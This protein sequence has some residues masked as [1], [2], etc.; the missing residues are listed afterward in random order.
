MQA[1]LHFL[2]RVCQAVDAKVVL[3]YDGVLLGLSSLDNDEDRLRQ[4]MVE[5][6][7]AFLWSCYRNVLDTLSNNQTLHDLYHKVC[8]RAF[9]IC[10]KYRKINFQRLVN[11]LRK[12]LKNIFYLNKQVRPL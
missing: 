6:W 4:E 9:K 10:E 11:T 8:E 5:P 3:P 2:Y 12:H 7:I 1:F